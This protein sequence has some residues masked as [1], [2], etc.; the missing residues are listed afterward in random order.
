M[1]EKT[2]KYPKWLSNFRINWKDVEPGMREYF[3]RRVGYDTNE[4][5]ESLP[6]V[7]ES[8][9]IIVEWMYGK[10]LDSHFWCAKGFHQARSVLTDSDKNLAMS[11]DSDYFMLIAWA[12]RR[13]YEEGIDN[14]WW[15]ENITLDEFVDDHNHEWAKSL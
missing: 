7:P 12:S 10:N 13:L 8:E 11:N 1:S 3:L 6:D 4:G 14:R 15:D 2:Y 9:D 5:G